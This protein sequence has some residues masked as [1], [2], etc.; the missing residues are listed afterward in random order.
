MRLRDIDEAVSSLAPALA[1]TA[2]SVGALHSLAP[3]HWVPI[4]ALSR[5]R[6]WSG[7]RTARIALACGFGHV[8]VSVGLGLAA[9]VTGEA[10]MRALGDKSGVIASAFLIAFGALYALW[11]ARHAIHRWRHGHDHA[12]GHHHGHDHGRSATTAWT[13]FA[14]YCA[15][16]CVAV[17]PILLAA[18]P[19]SRASTAAIVVVYE[20]AT[21]ATMVALTAVARAGAG[22]VRGAWVERWGDSAAGG[23][24]VA[25]GIVVGLL[26]W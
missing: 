17:V 2:A 20:A 25:T 26:G 5:A 6:G 23:L 13:L 10:A 11:G 9:L 14:I 12:H 18:A 24:I 3:D 7:R 21:I 16:P 15:D 22:V 1:V 8:T 19:L 4:A